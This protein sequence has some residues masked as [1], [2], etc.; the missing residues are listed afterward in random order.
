[1][2]HRCA[3]SQLVFSRSD[4]RTDHRVLLAAVSQ[5]TAVNLAQ[6][7]KE[8]GH[9]RIAPQVSR[10]LRKNKRAIVL[11][12]DERA[13]VYGVCLG[14]VVGQAVDDVPAPTRIE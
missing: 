8:A 9:I 12:V 3:E 10:V 14:V 2:R 7:E 13:V 1:M 4:K 11:G 6:P 5:R